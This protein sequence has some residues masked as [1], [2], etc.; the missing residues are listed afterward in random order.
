MSAKLAGALW[1]SICM[2]P[3]ENSHAPE[4]DAFPLGSAAYA[5]F[6]Q[7]ES[8]LNGNTPL[9]SRTFAAG[10]RKGRARIVSDDTSSSRSL[11]PG[12]E[13]RSRGIAAVTE[14]SS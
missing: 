14:S 1:I 12:C 5:V 4:P 8:L 2:S 3:E 11:Y 7:I 6:H 9:R 10:G 13:R